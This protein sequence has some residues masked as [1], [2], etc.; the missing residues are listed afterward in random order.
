MNTTQQSRIAVVTGSSRGLGRSMAL[1]LA[2][3]GVDVVVT[4]RSG[5][6]QANEVVAQITAQGRRAVALPLDVGDSASFA[7]ATNR[8]CFGVRY[9]AASCAMP[10]SNKGRERPKCAWYIAL[11]CSLLCAIGFRRVCRR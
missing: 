7:F 2:G 1:H 10:L 9:T 8:S 11:A 6:K 4:Y 3:Q 5:E